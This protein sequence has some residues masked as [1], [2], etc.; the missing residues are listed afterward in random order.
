MKRSNANLVF[1]NG[2]PDAVFKSQWLGE[3]LVAELNKRREG[4]ANMVAVDER[5]RND[6]PYF[7][8]LLHMVIHFVSVYSNG[9]TANNP[10]QINSRWSSFRQPIIEAA[11][12][13]VDSAESSYGIHALDKPAQPQAARDLLAGDTYLFGKTAGVSTHIVI[14]FRSLIALAS[15]QGV[16]DNAAPY[17]HPEMFVALARFFKNRESVGVVYKE[18]MPSGIY[19]T[20]VPDAMVALTAVAVSILFGSPVTSAHSSPPHGKIQ[21]ALL[22]LAEGRRSHFSEKFCVRSTRFTWIRFDL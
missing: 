15:R 18:L 10:P 5:A 9:I 8:Q 22:N 17:Q 21:L 6:V 19:G 11:R 4:S 2:F 13:L 14:T 3:A 20:Q 12:D 7:N 1:V 16:V